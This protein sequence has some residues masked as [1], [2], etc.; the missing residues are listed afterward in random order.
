[1][2]RKQLGGAQIVPS[3][4]TT[5]EDAHPAA[6][7]KVTAV[8]P[9]LECSESDDLIGQIARE[10]DGEKVGDKPT[11]APIAEPSQQDGTVE[12]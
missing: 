10:S 7:H 12:G 2:Q 11:T 6:S 1:M 3:K 9:Q 5:E 4:S 8:D